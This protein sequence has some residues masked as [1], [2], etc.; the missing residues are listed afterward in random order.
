VPV[1]ATILTLVDAGASLA[2]RAAPQASGASSGGLFYSSF[3]MPPFPGVV[4]TSLQIVARTSLAAHIATLDAVR[5]VRVV[6]AN[7]GGSAAASPTALPPLPPS[8]AVSVLFFL[9]NGC[10]TDA[11]VANIAFAPGGVSALPSQRAEGVLG[12][13]GAPSAPPPGAPSAAR[14]TRSDAL[15]LAAAL[16]VAT[17]HLIGTAAPR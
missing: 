9:E 11:L 14:G 16:A 10:V 7:T 17:G 2:I 6:P 5:L 8:V 4:N 3:A 13:P 12:A 1:G 15:L